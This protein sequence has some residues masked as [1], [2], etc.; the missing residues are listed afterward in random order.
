GQLELFSRRA[1]KQEHPRAM[2]ELEKLVLHLIHRE[3]GDVVDRS[4]P[5]AE[6]I[7]ALAR[8]FRSRLTSLVANWIRVGYCQGNFN[9]DNCAAGGFTLDYGP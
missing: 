2:E 5:T 1:R 3:Y 6:K 9:S 4:L 8:E 7:V